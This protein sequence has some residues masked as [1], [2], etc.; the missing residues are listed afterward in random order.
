[1]TKKKNAYAQGLAAL[2]WKKTPA[3]QRSEA[4]R[5]AV[6]ARWAKAKGST[7]RP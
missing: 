6:N 3:A 5:K 4:A 1:M 7:A 2:R